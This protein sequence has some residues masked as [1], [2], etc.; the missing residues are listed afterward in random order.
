LNLHFFNLIYDEFPNSRIVFLVRDP[1]DV[2]ASH[3]K[4]F[5]GNIKG[6]EKAIRRWN[7]SYDSFRWLTKKG[8]NVYIVKYED[9]VL[10]N[11]DVISGILGFLDLNEDG[12]SMDY[13]SQMET[14]GVHK[15]DHHQNLKK[16]ISGASI[17]KWKKDL[18][19]KYVQMIEKRCKKGMRY[20]NY[21]FS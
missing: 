14:L 15:F 6:I 7:K 3:L 8:A 19:Q 4:F 5:K 13:S 10:R 20:F 16:P 1:R 9:L 2:G 11:E 18:P 12:L 17:G 21:S